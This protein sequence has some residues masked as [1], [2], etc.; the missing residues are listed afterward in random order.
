MGPISAI[1]TPIT[2]IEAYANYDENMEVIDYRTIAEDEAM[3]HR[4]PVRTPDG[5]LFIVIHEFKKPI[6]NLAKLQLLAE[7]LE[8]T[9]EDDAFSEDAEDRFLVVSHSDM[10]MFKEV[11]PHWV[12]D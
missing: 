2:G 1:H 7:A 8:L 5:K 10:P 3:P 9:L 12:A 6:K 11:S 4:K